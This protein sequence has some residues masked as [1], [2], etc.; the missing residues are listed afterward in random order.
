MVRGGQDGQVLEPREF[1]E[2]TDGLSERG[3]ESE[4]ER[5][6]EDVE[7]V[8]VK[9]GGARSLPMLSKIGK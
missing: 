1:N 7:G 5:W 4:H 6:E 2:E 9:V 3:L 8:C